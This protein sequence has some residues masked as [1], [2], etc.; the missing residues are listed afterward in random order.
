[1]KRMLQSWSLSFPEVEILASYFAK[2]LLYGR[3]LTHI[4]YFAISHTSVLFSS[5]VNNN[6]RMLWLNSLKTNNTTVSYCYRL[7]LYETSSGCSSVAR[8]DR[9]IRLTLSCPF[10]Q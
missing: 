5:G 3:L 10:S 6:D 1:M 4:R 2:P 8:L 7:S 9:I